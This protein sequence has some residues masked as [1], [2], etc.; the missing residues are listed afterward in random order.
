MTL[1]GLFRLL[2]RLCADS[3]KPFVLMIDEI[4]TASDNQVFLDFLGLL[5]DYYMKR[6]KLAA[7]YSVILAG[8]Y[9]IRNMKHKY[10]S[11]DCGF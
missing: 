7:F 5:C 3:E 4:D 6:E 2:S 8:V 1:A 9:D 10:R 11:D